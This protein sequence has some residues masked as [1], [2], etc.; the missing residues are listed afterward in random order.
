MAVNFGLHDG[1][2]L[3]CGVLFLAERPLLAVKHLSL[4]DG[5]VH[6]GESLR[7]QIRCHAS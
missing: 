2:S 1:N 4:G 5:V 7:S 6:G 3:G